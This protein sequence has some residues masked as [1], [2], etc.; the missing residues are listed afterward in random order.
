MGGGCR[1]GLCLPPALSQRARWTRQRCAPFHANRR[2]SAAAPRRRGPRCGEGVAVSRQHMAVLRRRT[3][4]CADRPLQ[5]PAYDTALKKGA[6]VSERR[7]FVRLVMFERER[8]RQGLRTI[9]IGEIRF[10][11]NG[12]VDEFRAMQ[13]I[14]RWPGINTSTPTHKFAYMPRRASARR[15]REANRSHSRSYGEDERQSNRRCGACRT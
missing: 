6:D 14:D 10:D 5:L 1:E 7:N 12:L 11:R 3:W 9:T 4:K 8:L 2:L 15:V 13:E